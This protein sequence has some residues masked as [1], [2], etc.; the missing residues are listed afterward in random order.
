MS[1]DTKAERFEVGDSTR[2]NQAELTEQERRELWAARQIAAAKRNWRIAG[3]VIAA[4]ALWL[5]GFAWKESGYWHGW[6]DCR[7]SVTCKPK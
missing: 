3:Y 2:M 7:D 6:R 5:A 4:L 1:R